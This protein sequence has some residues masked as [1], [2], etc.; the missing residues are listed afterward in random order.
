MK[1]QAALIYVQ[2]LPWY[3]CNFNLKKHAWKSR[4]CYPR[5]LCMNSKLLSLGFVPNRPKIR[6][7]RSVINAVV[8][9]EIRAKNLMLLPQETCYTFPRNQCWDLPRKQCQIRTVRF[10]INV[11]VPLLKIR[12][13]N[14]CRSYLSPWDLCNLLN[15]AV[16]P[17][18]NMC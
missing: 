14:K 1:Q 16:L 4:L 18:R 10:A 15:A 9:L 2:E 6:I 13:S 12:A 3:P 17:P 8:H 11:A 5:F 7:V